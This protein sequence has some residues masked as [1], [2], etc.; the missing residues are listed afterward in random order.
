[1]L[2]TSLLDSLSA[3]HR[4]LE[5]DL[6]CV[7]QQSHLKCRDWNKGPMFFFGHQYILIGNFKSCPLDIDVFQGSYLKQKL[8]QNEDPVSLRS[9]GKVT[10]GNI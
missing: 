4:N 10:R 2:D 6:L 8:S 9:G 5:E 3:D 1:M 7:T